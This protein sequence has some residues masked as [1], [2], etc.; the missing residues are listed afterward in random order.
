MSKHKTF[1]RREGKAWQGFGAEIEERERGENGRA[2]HLQV[3]GV[4]L[5]KGL[6]G[7]LL[8]GTNNFSGHDGRQRI[9]GTGPKGLRKNGDRAGSLQRR[10][11]ASGLPRLVAAAAP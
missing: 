11:G 3:K 8:R 9:V 6:E 7:A 1:V 2:A 4:E 10:F 5:G